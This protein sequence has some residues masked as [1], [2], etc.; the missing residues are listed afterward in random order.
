[1]FYRPIDIGKLILLGQFTVYGNFW[2]KADGSE[3]TPTEF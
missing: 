3:F 1:L 2:D